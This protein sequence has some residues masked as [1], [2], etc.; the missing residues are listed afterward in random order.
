MTEFISNID[1]LGAE[2]LPLDTDVV[3]KMRV[4]IT[5]TL[6]PSA[7]A[8]HLEALVVKCSC[9]K[10]NAAQASPTTLSAVPS[11]GSS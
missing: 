2:K 1:F 3:Y 9:K 11:V 4:N 10:P 6:L 5:A 8:H 7:E